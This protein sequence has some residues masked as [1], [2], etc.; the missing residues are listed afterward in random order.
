MQKLRK[1]IQENRQL[2]SYMRTE[3]KQIESKIELLKQ[4]LAVERGAHN[5]AKRSLDEARFEIKR[6]LEVSRG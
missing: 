3:E 2:I 4:E 6:S 5:V 1:V